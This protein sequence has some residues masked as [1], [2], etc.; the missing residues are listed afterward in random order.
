MVWLG[1]V[2]NISHTSRCT[3]PHSVVGFVISCITTIHSFHL[4]QNYLQNFLWLL[5]QN[6]SF[7]KR[8]GNTTPEEES[9]AFY[10]QNHIITLTFGVP[11]NKNLVRLENFFPQ[12]QEGTAKLLHDESIGLS[13]SCELWNRRTCFCCQTCPSQMQ[14]MRG[15]WPLE[16]AISQVGRLPCTDKHITICSKVITHWRKHPKPKRN[17]KCWTCSKSQTLREM[18]P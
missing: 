1:A 17:P 15:A 12:F 13:C 4:V 3:L 11:L 9:G 7:S 18:T 14:D 5:A 2:I 10:P 6:L 16:R 8:R